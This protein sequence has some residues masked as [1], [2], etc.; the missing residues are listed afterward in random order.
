MPSALRQPAS[1]ALLGDA[2]REVMAAQDRLWMKNAAPRWRAIYQS[3]QRELARLR[4]LQ[5]KS[6]RNTQ[7]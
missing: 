6:R 4:E 5:R 1:S 2:F 3:A 7:M